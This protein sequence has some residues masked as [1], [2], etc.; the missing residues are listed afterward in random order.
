[1]LSLLP[2]PTLIIHLSSQP[3]ESGH[4]HTLPDS[5]PT[6][7]EEKPVLISSYYALRE[8]LLPPQLTHFQ[9]SPTMVFWLFLKAEPTSRPLHWLMHQASLE[10]VPLT[11][12]SSRVLR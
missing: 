7:L 4:S 12:S 9:L 1:M 6:Y 8:L 5:L 3:P 10:V 2:A 11:S